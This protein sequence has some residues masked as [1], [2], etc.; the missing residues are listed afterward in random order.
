MQRWYNIHKSINAIHHI[1]KSKNKNHMI[2]SM[3]AYKA[4]DKLQCPFMIKTLR[5]VGIEGAYLNII[6]AIYEKTAANIIL[7]GQNLKYFPIR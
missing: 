5:K 2:I 6:K 3:D 1:Y 7:R 4:C